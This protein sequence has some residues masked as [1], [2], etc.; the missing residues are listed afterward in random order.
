MHHVL[1]S[2][3]SL[4]KACNITQSL[5]CYVL[6]KIWVTQE[7]YANTGLFRLTQDLVD[8]KT[9]LKKTKQK[10]NKTF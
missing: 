2:P 8:T 10:Q 9:M 1:L 5:C 3:E 4:Q 7:N 6:L